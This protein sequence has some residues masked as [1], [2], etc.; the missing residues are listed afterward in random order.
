MTTT[1]TATFTP[2]TMPEPCR[3]CFWRNTTPDTERLAAVDRG[4]RRVCKHA[5]LIPGRYECHGERAHVLATAPKTRVLLVG[6]G[7]SKQAQ[8][9]A[10]RDLYTGG[11]FSARRAYADRTG[12]PWWVIS[13]KHH[14][15][16]QTDTLAPYDLALTELNSMKRTGWGCEVAMQL[17]DALVRREIDP[18]LCELEIHAGAAYVAAIRLWVG[19][20]RILTP[21]EGLGVGQQLAW[22][23]ARL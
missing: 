21:L 10:A 6:C 17:H 4:E 12:A 5:S 19:G 20:I 16:A 14:L 2:Q 8:P 15:V 11:L 1:L 18:L 22:Y 9:A 23:K 7:K 13:A 3:A